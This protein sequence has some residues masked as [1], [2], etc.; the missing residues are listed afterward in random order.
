MDA[1]WAGRTVVVAD[2]DRQLED[3]GAIVVTT[4]LDMI[5]HLELGSIT[6]VVLA[7]RASRDELATF[8]H[9]TYPQVRI[10]E[11]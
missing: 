5:V 8:L 3:T 7:S 2:S 9:E 11:A 4:P 6:T 1:C 10:E